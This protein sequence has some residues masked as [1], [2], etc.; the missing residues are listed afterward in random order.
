LADLDGDGNLDLI[1][2]SYWPGD[3]SLFRGLGAGR[4]APGTILQSK[5]GGNL[6]AGPA[7]KNEEEPEMDSLA[8]SPTLADWEGDGDLD[9]LVGNIAGR[10]ILIVNEG[11]AQQPAFGAKRA[12]QAAGL[13]LQVNGGDAGPEAADW[14]GDG[15]WDLL[16]GGGDGSVWFYR[17]AGTK[18][19]P[20]FAAGVALVTSMEAAIVEAGA[21]PARP[22]QRAKPT[23]ADWNRDGLPDLLVGDFTSQAKL[24]PILTTEQFAE[25]DRLRSRRDEL[26]ENYP[27]D[28]D[29]AAQRNW[30]EESSKLYEALEPLE[31][32]Q[33]MHGF[34]WVY[35]RKPAAVAAPAS[36][37]R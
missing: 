4:F 9:L 20:A 12:V 2:G 16:V 23:V 24:E 31:A 35:L 27:E 21:T 13:D 33:T 5:Y 26:N 22:G 19:A 17:N 6:N 32:G 15:L 36:A 28:G 25:R 18:T 3:L 29:E 34:V 30:S 8:A 14:D 1:S 10:L 37:V 11:T 7:W